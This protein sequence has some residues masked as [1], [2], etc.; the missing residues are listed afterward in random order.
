[1]GP[2]YSAGSNS[3][4]ISGRPD[5]RAWSTPTPRLP[6][7]EPHPCLYWS[8]PTHL[9][10]PSPN[11]PPTL[12]AIISLSRPRH[13]DHDPCTV[14]NLS[15]DHDRIARIHMSARHDPQPAARLRGFRSPTRHA[16]QLHP[17]Q[18]GGG[19]TDRTSTRPSRLADVTRCRPTSRPTTATVNAHV[20][21]DGLNE[22]DEMNLYTPNPLLDS[23]YGPGD[24][25]WLYRQQDVDGATL[26]EPAV[27]ACADQ[28][29]Q[30]TR[31]PKPAPAVRA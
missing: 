31:R 9:S 25:E 11:T 12:A 8:L 22:A 14:P 13:P 7:G 16:D 18:I 23:P 1:M 10:V 29:H 26:T 28:L 17:Q 3:T 4:A 24:L 30:L 6:A 2:T 20:H 21:S 15:A 27:A 19:P 5:R